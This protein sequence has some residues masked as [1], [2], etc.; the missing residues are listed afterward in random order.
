MTEYH[1]LADIF[2]LMEG[3]EFD[4]LVADIKANGV[5]EKIWLYEGKI[6]DGRNREHAAAAAGVPCST[7]LYEGDDPV[8]FV[9][10]KNIKRR[11]LDEPLRAMI[12]A[13]PLRRA[14]EDLIERE[15]RAQADLPF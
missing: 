11:H 9:I 6:L 15:E 12:A 10:A 13:K 7:C 4:A 14:L 5:R 2:P 1:P 8:G 3:A